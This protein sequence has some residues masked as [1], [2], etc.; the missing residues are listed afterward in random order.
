MAAKSRIVKWQKV[1]EVQSKKK[2]NGESSPYWK[3]I[4]N[5]NRPNP[6]RDSNQENSEFPSANPDVLPELDEPVENLTRKIIKRDWRQIKFSKRE[7]EVLLRLAKGMTQEAVAKALN[8]SRSSVRVMLVRI[9]KKSSKWLVTKTA[10]S[11]QYSTEEES[12]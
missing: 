8:I 6:Y 2:F 12:E 5:S 4:E 9:Q 11:G 3:F 1:R 10:N 7:Q